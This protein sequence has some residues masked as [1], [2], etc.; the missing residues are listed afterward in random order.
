MSE[1]HTHASPSNTA[2]S[3][4][5]CGCGANPAADRTNTAAE[6]HTGAT[7]GYTTEFQVTGMTCG[8]CVGAVTGE[9]T[10]SVS[11]VKDVQICHRV[12]SLSTAINRS[13][14]LPSQPPSKGPATSSYQDH[15]AIKPAG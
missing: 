15:F 7:G 10:D 2:R 14:K 3:G 4:C 6:A 5:G 11:G 8:H 13:P 12:R 1:I 9:L